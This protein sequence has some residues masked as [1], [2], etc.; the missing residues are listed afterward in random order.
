MACQHRSKYNRTLSQKKKNT[1]APSEATPRPLEKLRLHIQKT[2]SLKLQGAHLPGHEVHLNLGKL[3]FYF[4]SY[5]SKSEGTT[6]EKLRD[7]IFPHM[8]YIHTIIYTIYRIGRGQH[9]R[10]TLIKLRHAILGVRGCHQ[11]SEE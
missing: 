1:T 10:H 2:E 3:H 7:N 5:S 9:I 8:K 4:M 6:S 11:P